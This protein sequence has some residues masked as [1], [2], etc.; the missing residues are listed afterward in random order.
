MTVARDLRDDGVRPGAGERPP[1]RAPGST[2]TSGTL[3]PLH[4]RRV[5]TPKRGPAFDSHQ[6]GDRQARSRASPQATPDDVDA[7]VAAA[8]KALPGVGGARAATSARALPLRA[9][10]RGPEA[11]APLRRARDARQRQ[12]DP[13]DAR[14]R[15]PAGRAPLL[16]PR[17]LGAAAGDAS[18]PA[19]CRSAS[20]GQI[21]PWNFPLLMLAWKIAPALALGNT[22]VL[23]PA[24]FTSLTALLF[25]EICAQAGA[26]ARA[27]STSS[28]ATATPAQRSSTIPASTRSPSPA[29][30]RSAASSARRPRA[31]GK[32]LSLEL[33]GKSPVHRLRRR[34]PRQ[35]GRRA[36]SMRSGSTR[37]RSAAPARACWC[38]KAIADA[39]HREAASARMETLRVGDPLDKAID[40]GAIVAPVQLERIQRAGGSRASPRARRSGSRRA[41]CP[42]EGCFY[43]ADAVH[44]R[45][46]PPST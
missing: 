21:I 33:G 16:P 6:P 2:R 7:A 30:P 23:K 42:S 19:A 41:A 36:W 45:R 22:V 39:L 44:R 24:E 8:R 34:R 13:R 28:P 18:S 14:H 20:C 12:A 5:A 9:R 3:R 11:L 4:R 26:A 32:T 15:H 17:R 38:R 31:R 40:I 46:S 37:A 35:R 1:K 27:S 43:P 10:A 25:A 29:R